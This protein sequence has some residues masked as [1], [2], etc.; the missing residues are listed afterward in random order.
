MLTEPPRVTTQ[1]APARAQVRT[2]LG[3]V[4]RLPAALAFGGTFT[5]VLLYALR[6]GAYDVIVFESYGLVIWCL[7]AVGIVVGLLP[8]SRP[9]RATVLLLA[10]LLG[11]AIWTGI[12]LAWTESAERTTIELARTVDYLGVI[13]L[14]A[15]VLDRATW[16][17]AAAGLG[18]GALA[19]CVLA[20]LSRLDPGAFP[21]DL[22]AIALRTDRLSYPFGYWNAV[23]AWGAMSVAIGLAW[24]AHDSVRWRRA[25]VLSLVPIA[26]ATVYL[27]YSRTAAGG[28]AVALVVV[29]AASRNRVTALLHT[30]LALGTSAA[31]IAAIRNAPQIATASGARG[32]LG[33]AGA[34]AF[35][36][37]LCAAGAWI[38]GAARTDR[39]RVPRAVFRPPATA[40]VVIALI[41]AAVLGPVEVSRAWHSFTHPVATQ[42]SDPA[43]R[44]L[45]LSGSRYYVWKSAVNAFARDPGA[46]T[47]AGTFAF[48]WNRHA[49]DPEFLHDTHNIWLQNMAELGAPGLVLMLAV[50]GGA[51]AVAGVARLRARRRASAGAA[52]AAVAALAV[53]LLAA[54][55]DWMWES[56]A[57]TVL[58]LAGIAA[59][60]A[61]LSR[62]LGA[63]RWRTRVPLVVLA[64]AAAAIQVPGLLSTAELRR[65]QAAERSGNANLALAWAN[66]AVDAEPWSASAYEQRGLVLE[67]A[68]RLDSAAADLTRA[69]SHER[70][71]FTHWLLLARIETERGRLTA[72]TRD[73][74]EAYALRP[75]AAVFTLAPYFSVR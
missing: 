61:R 51:L 66:D 2:P 35:A 20:V 32:A 49:T 45:N 62:P 6:G 58:A 39:L 37:G 17:P 42:S 53:Y 60:G 65:S 31:V 23:G 36:A 75:V 69:V 47:G 27:T 52:T 26:A 63:V 68:G 59:I 46:G 19:V 70:T 11:Y 67:A 9:S 56:T 16:R 29:I 72:A 40:A 38:A 30:L 48:W 55:V 44:L 5:L 12:S 43:A 15:C 21:A 64:S 54:S 25:L 7:I 41:A 34:I 1:L 28:A 14:L 22:V 10:A 50:V 74:R 73:Y 8:R 4:S 24:S 18:A 13:V 71:N 33:V 57:V 3:R